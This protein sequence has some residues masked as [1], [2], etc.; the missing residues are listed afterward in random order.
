[1]NDDGTRIVYDDGDRE[2]RSTRSGAPQVEVYNDPRR[3]AWQSVAYVRCALRYGLCQLQRPT[4][5]GCRDPSDI[6]L[7]AVP[8]SH[9]RAVLAINLWQQSAILMTHQLVLITRCALRGSRE[10]VRD[11]LEHAIMAVM[12]LS[13]LTTVVGNGGAS[14]G[15]EPL[16]GLS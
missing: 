15:D 13:E 6:L 9:N 2:K 8:P 1:M 7:L 16:V 14:G 11:I 5:C 4:A 10:S 3:R 12:Q